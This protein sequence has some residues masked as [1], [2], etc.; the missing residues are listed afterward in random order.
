MNRSLDNDIA[1]IGMAARLPGANSVDEF[2]DNLVNGRSALRRF[3]DEEV[4]AGVQ[5]YDRIGMVL[6]GKQSHEETFVK[7]G[8]VLDD[9]E[10]FDADFFGY[11]P[12]EAE[13]L[14]PQQRHFLEVCWHTMEHAGYVPDTYAGLIGVYAGQLMSRYFM[15]NVWSNREIMYTPKDLI[16]G[17]G[18]EADYIANRVSYKFNLRGPAI[19]V[20]TACSTSLTAIHLAAQ[21]LLNGETDMALAGGALLNVPSVYGYLYREGSMTSPDGLVRAFDADAKGTVFSMGG[22]GAVLLKRAEEALEDGDTVYALISGSAINNDGSHKVGYT[23]PAIEGQVQVIEQALGLTEFAPESIT[24]IEAHGTGTPLGDP[25]EISA[26]SQVYGGNTDDRQYCAIGSAKTNIGHLAVAAGVAAT[27]KATLS[28]Y[29]KQLVPSLNFSQPNPRIDFEN[30]PFFVNTELQPWQPPAGVPRRCAVSSF[31]VGGSNAHLVMEEAPAQH[32]TPHDGRYLL[33]PLSARTETAL[34]TLRETLADYLEQHSGINL[35]DVAHTLQTGRKYHKH[36][37][38]IVANNA[39]DL[40]ASL[41][42]ADRQND[43]AIGVFA[44]DKAKQPVVMFTGQG[45]QY[46]HM[47]KDLYAEDAVI[48]AAMDECFAHLQHT[49]ALDLR[50]VMYPDVDADQDAAA[51][52]LKRTDMTQPALFVVEYAMA[53]WLQTVGVTWQASIGHSIGEIVAAHFAGVMSLA[54][55]L[56]L[57]V[58]RGRL[59]QSLPSGD[60][61]AVTA[62]EATVNDAIAQLAAQ[63]GAD[64][65]QQVAIAALN[66]PGSC[67]VS[68]THTAIAALTTLLES[69]A[70]ST[71]KLH[72]SHAFHSPMMEPILAD[73][74]AQ[75]DQV[76]LFPPQ[77]AVMSNVTGEWLTEAQ[78]TDPNYWAQHLRGAVRFAD[79][80][81][82]I[83]QAI[84]DAAFIEVGPGTTLTTLAKRSLGKEG[85]VSNMIRSLKTEANDTV[86]AWRGLA[87]LWANGVPIHWKLQHQS[88]TAP[89]QRMRIALPGYPFERKRYWVE[90]SHAADGTELPK[91]GKQED[92]QD[93]FFTPSWTRSAKATSLPTVN[94]D[95]EVMTYLVFAN[96]DASSQALVDKLKQQQHRVMCVYAANG[97]TQQDA[98]TFSVQPDSK[99][100]AIALFDT[101]QQRE[102]LPQRLIHLWSLATALPQI[103]ASGAVGDTVNTLSGAYQN[104]MQRCFYSPIAIAQAIGELGIDGAMDLSFV[105][106]NAQEVLGGE[107]QHPLASALLG[108]INVIPYEF[109]HLACRLIDVDRLPLSVANI[110]AIL[111]EPDIAH[112]PDEDA[113]VALRGNYR[114]QRGWEAQPLAAT[115]NTEVVQHAVQWREQGTYFITGG[116]GGLG[117]AM[118]EQLAERYQVKLALTGRSLLPARERWDAIVNGED[119]T[120]SASVKQRISKVQQLEALGAQVLVLKAD[121]TDYYSM[122]QAVRDTQDALGEIH[123]VIHSAGVAGGGLVQLKTAEQSET[124]LA[125]KVLGSM[126]LAELFKQNPP[127]IFLLNSSLF[128]VMGGMG[129]VDYTA[130]NNFLDA[131]AYHLNAQ[132]SRAISINWDGWEEI[133]MAA[134][135][136]AGGPAKFSDL[137]ATPS[138]IKHP[139]F[140]Q[141]Q[142]VDAHETQYHA[143]LSAT[144]WI[145]DEHRIQGTPAMPGTAWIDMAATIAKQHWAAEL[146]TEQASANLV[147]RDVFFMSPMMF[148]Q[149]DADGARVG[150]VRI[151][152]TEVSQDTTPPTTQ[153]NFLMESENDGHW[154]PHASVCA[155]LDRTQTTVAFDF[156]AVVA[157]CSETSHDVSAQTAGDDD[158][159]CLGQHWQTHKTV[160]FG[161]H[162]VLNWFEL[163]PTLTDDLTAFAL[164]PALLDMATGPSCG[165]LLANA[166]PALKDV[167]YLPL[168]YGELRCIAPLTDKLFVYGSVDISHDPSLETLSLDYVITDELG[169]VLMTVSGFMLKKVAEGANLADAPATAASANPVGIGETSGI[170]PQ[171]GLAALDRIIA[172]QHTPQVVVSTSHLPTLLNEMRASK[173]QSV[174]GGGTHERPD[175]ASDYVA[176]SSK[177]EEILAAIF[178]GVLG[179]EQVG[180]NDNFFELGMDSVLG[181]QVVSQARK[182]NIQLSP[183]QLFDRQTIVELAEIIP[184]MEEDTEQAATHAKVSDYQAWYLQQGL[185]VAMATFCLPLAAD[186]RLTVQN[187][188]AAL[189]FLLNERAELSQQFVQ[190]E[191]KQWCNKDG[192]PMHISVETHTVTSTDELRA[193]TLC[194]EAELMGAA[195]VTVQPSDNTAPFTVAVWQVHRALAS[196]PQVQA[197]MPVWLRLAEANATDMDPQ[198][199]VDE[200]PELSVHPV[201]TNIRDHQTMASHCCCGLVKAP[202][203]ASLDDQIAHISDVFNMSHDEVFVLATQASVQ[204]WAGERVISEV[205]ILE[206][207][208]TTKS[209]N[210]SRLLAITPL[211]AELNATSSTDE[212]NALKANYRDTL[213]QATDVTAKTVDPDAYSVLIQQGEQLLSTHCIDFG[214][215]I[216]VQ[217]ATETICANASVSGVY[218]CYS[219]TLISAREAEVLAEKIVDTV[220]LLH[221]LADNAGG[222]VFSTSDFDDAELSAGELDNL[223]DQL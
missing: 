1:I 214:R 29:H 204:Q 124:V 63:Q 138:D 120:V 175:L 105:S 48:R 165:H 183:E 146:A 201:A 34:Q 143:L 110:T 130:A 104:A 195:L 93:W 30:S 174:S 65:A 67:V 153:L 118:A 151:T 177:V 113:A 220:A 17:I 121:V 73:F 157:E 47:A 173:N 38:A 32:S 55:A 4:Q 142:R 137:P 131:F 19:N 129:Q 181:I 69:A 16:A 83:A 51:E 200:L 23:A 85:V 199:I 182:Y 18:S 98:T 66:A 81:K 91:F 94:S 221:T 78:A 106:H 133:G 140:Q 45:S 60:M 172:Q 15:I 92:L 7:A 22:V 64:I 71:Q 109:T 70:I 186:S 155:Q 179:I 5:Q 33:F 222:K 209:I 193:L 171:E 52:Q 219:K 139:L 44:A 180:I 126:I 77:Q 185:G 162:T 160:F 14:D 54:D 31:G 108:P 59:M 166:L 2:W 147:L 192:E 212:V 141:M 13:L 213:L 196:G 86:M 210:Q 11:I 163:S 80:I 215:S 164:H 206:E 57:V 169:T 21:A 136:F 100:D 28:L 9:I 168:S 62:D 116:L 184:A 95:D 176:P 87:Q 202:F 152:V 10:Y 197:L 49:C 82:H 27:I 190:D 8:Y 79:G 150:R 36:R 97:F 211:T 46:V 125:P 223:L 42:S 170:L 217:R 99:A 58:A 135:L 101:L 218:L 6:S 128:A 90:P 149:T 43:Q 3:T 117:L 103:D 194:A 188:Q 127:E 187:Y 26:L 68:G 102:Q 208:S 189:T 39:V 148:T 154:L 88:N 205:S 76:S 107:L 56:S 25:I 53:K 84:P 216:S 144:H 119:D 61:V 89:A 159:L 203:S 207:A 37:F 178:A 111:A 198:P 158:F 12:S 72:T 50:A 191:N 123:G 167:V 20:Q 75:F 96:Q 40:I 74:I 24:Y 145:I 132:G 114:W 134:N 35:A 161:Q 41:R 115:H 112:K 156:D 122:A